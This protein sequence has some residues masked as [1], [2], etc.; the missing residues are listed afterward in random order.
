[1]CL[2]AAF[3]AA[4]EALQPLLHTS[5]AMYTIAHIVL[6][7]TRE[8]SNFFAFRELA[9]AITPITEVFL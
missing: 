4:S 2:Q 6:A 5:A 3:A 8:I 7:K 9:T 1:M